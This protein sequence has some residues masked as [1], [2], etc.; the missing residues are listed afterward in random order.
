M[1]NLNFVFGFVAPC[2]V[3]FAKYRKD[4][5]EQ[6]HCCILCLRKASIVSKSSLGFVITEPYNVFNLSALSMLVE[7]PFAIS[8]VICCPPTQILAETLRKGGLIF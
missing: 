5:A 1:L 3:V 6:Q 7:S 2:R 8:V 4:P